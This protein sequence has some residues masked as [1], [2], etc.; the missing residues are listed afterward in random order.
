MIAQYMIAIPI[1]TKIYC[2][3]WEFKF[4]KFIYLLN[5]KL[6]WIAYVEIIFSTSWTGVKM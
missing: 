4:F 1:F 2:G 6:F 3:P 5:W